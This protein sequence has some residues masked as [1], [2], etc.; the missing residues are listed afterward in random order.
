MNVEGKLW[1]AMVAQRFYDY[2]ITDNKYINTDLQKGSIKSMSGCWEHTAMSWSAL[3]DARQRK[4]SLVLLWLDLANAYGSVPHQLIFFA[5]R[6]YH[7]PAEWIRLVELYY[8]GQWGRLTVDEIVSEWELFERGIF[9]GCTLSVILFLAAIN[10]I[11]EY[12]S[13]GRLPRYQLSGG[14]TLPLI[15][16]FMDDLALALKSV[17]AAKMCLVRVVKAL[18]WARMKPKPPKS[19]SL[20]MVK[21]RV[22]DVQP[23][24]VDSLEIPSVQKK[25]VKSLGRVFDSSVSDRRAKKQL[26]TKVIDS[27]KVIDKS[28]YTGYMKLW[29]LN[30]VLL[31]KIKCQLTV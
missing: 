26:E 29:I 24:V 18:K 11:I 30:N 3:Q 10:V 6:R 16:G 19:R 25:P 27:T 5:L 14:L 17:P 4:R 21:G 13:M 20:V 31:P 15:R 28:D 2:L 1:W 23:F 22:M 7:V 8:G 12:V 9:A